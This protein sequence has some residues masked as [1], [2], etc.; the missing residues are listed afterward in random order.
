MRQHT[1]AYGSMRTRQIADFETK[2]TEV[3][4]SQDDVSIRQH[5]SAYV[6]IRQHTSAG[7]KRQQVAVQRTRQVAVEVTRVCGLKL[8]VYATSALSYLCV[9]LVY[10]SAAYQTSRSFRDSAH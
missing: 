4:F 9:L 10:G 8:L 7:C 3:R 6:S 5:T 1:S 2:S